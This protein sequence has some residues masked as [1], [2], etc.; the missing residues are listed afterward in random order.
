MPVRSVRTYPPVRLQIRGRRKGAGDGLV[1]DVG[2][3]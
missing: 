1:D 3:Q 2:A